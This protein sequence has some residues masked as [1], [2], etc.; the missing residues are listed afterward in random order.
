MVAV[1][2]MPMPSKC[3]ECRFW[4]EGACYALGVRVSERDQEKRERPDWCPLI[5][6]TDDGK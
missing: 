3:G 6:L 1:D 4:I 2:E 5:D